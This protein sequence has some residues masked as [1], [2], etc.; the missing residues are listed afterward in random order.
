MTLNITKSRT[1]QMVEHKISTNV[2]LNNFRFG[3]VYKG[4]AIHITRCRT[5]QLL[6]QMTGIQPYTIVYLQ[7]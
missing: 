3:N 7:M 4:V 6:K 5:L 1:R 2:R